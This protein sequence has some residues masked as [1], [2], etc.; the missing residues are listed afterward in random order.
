MSMKLNKTLAALTQPNPST[1][2]MLAQGNATSTIRDHCW[3]C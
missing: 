2:G 1:D 3:L